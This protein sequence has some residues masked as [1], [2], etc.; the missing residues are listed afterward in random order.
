LKREFC[1]IIFI[2]C[3]ITFFFISCKKE[4]SPNTTTNNTRTVYVDSLNGWKKYSTGSNDAIDVFF[5]DSIKG[6][7]LSSLG[8]I[9]KTSDGGKTWTDL[10][11]N[12]DLSNGYSNLFATNDGYTYSI[13]RKY[14]YRFKNDLLIDSISFGSLNDVYFLNQGT[15]F[16]STS[17][18]L[19][20]TT[21]YGKTWKSTKL[22]PRTNISN[23]IYN[24][25]Y[26]YDDTAGWVYFNNDLY[27]TTRNDS[28]W[29]VSESKF[30]GPQSIFAVT[31]D[32]VF[33]S[34]S[35]G[36]YKSTNAGKNFV[37][38]KSN[39]QRNYYNDLHFVTSNIGFCGNKNFIFKT[40]DGGISWK[41]ELAL[42]ASE[43]IVEIHF[44]D[45][46]HGWACTTQGNILIY[47]K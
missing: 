46:N 28:S 37:L 25:L 42:K 2:K 41:E 45:A 33:I 47:K 34:D 10:K 32:I 26:F 30:F 3:L 39:I 4:I 19:L 9:K 18:S 35:L 6:Y 5:I 15:G 14:L 24:S 7:V 20:K 27:Y 23:E 31:K 44:L 11:Q 8:I 40:I 38:L 16:A 13:S 21:D 36:I 22:I 43:N 1:K 17:N 29:L 12:R